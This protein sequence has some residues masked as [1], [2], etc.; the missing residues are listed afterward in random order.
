MS[1]PDPP[2]T[3]DARRRRLVRLGAVLLGAVVAVVVAIAVSS[4][5]GGSTSGSQTGSGTTGTVAGAPTTRLLAGIPQS[6]PVLGRP[7]APV[8]V[9]EFADLQCPFCREAALGEVA[10]IVGRDVRPGR[11]GMEFQPLAFIGP[12]S[13][14]AGRFVEAAGLQ[15]RLWHAAELL[16]AQQGPENS[17]W[18]TDELLR[19]VAA[20]IPG[21]DAR[22]ALSDMSSAAVTARLRAADALAQRHGVQ[23]TP[24][25][26]VGRG[27]AL[28]AVDTQGLQAAVDAAVAQR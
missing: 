9:V 12:D 7:R 13:E 14:K 28:R 8:R 23:S 17:G 25:F 20:A 26:L 22:R 5:G 19:R 4:G 27:A 6:G 16:Y 18:V 21:L 3:R 24:T 1:S 11:V 10:Q 15:D 2:S